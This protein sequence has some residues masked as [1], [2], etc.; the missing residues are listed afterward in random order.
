MN[1]TLESMEMIWKDKEETAIN[2]DNKEKR[3]VDATIV[4]ITTEK[5]E[6]KPKNAY[7]RKYLAATAM[8]DS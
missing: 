2:V 4:E 6:E 3:I 1:S 7:S 8:Y 5:S